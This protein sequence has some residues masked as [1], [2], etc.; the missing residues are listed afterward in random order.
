MAMHIR[1][2]DFK[3]ACIDLAT[4]N[5]TYYSWNLLPSLPDH[6]E[7]PEG[8]SWG[9]NTP[10]NTEK[11]MEHCLPTFDAIVE[12]V[13]E[14][15]ADFASASQGKVRILDVMYILTNDDSDWLRRLKTA[16]KADGWHTIVTTKDLMLDLEQTGVN[17]AVDM[18]IA[19]KAAVFIGNGVSYTF[20][21]HLWPLIMSF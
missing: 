7:P 13:R 11:Y 16:L 21:S 1:R 2:G 10:E 5:S 6:F 3:Q 12:K 20:M 8:G 9:Y 4:W 15:K 19:R 14:A 17:M 18:D